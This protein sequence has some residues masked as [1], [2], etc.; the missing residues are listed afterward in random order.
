MTVKLS[1]LTKWIQNDLKIDVDEIQHE[2]FTTLKLDVSYFDKNVEDG[3]I[4]VPVDLLEPFGKFIT[5]LAKYVESEKEED[6]D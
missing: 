3:S 1:S 2:E 5:N 6:V 4:E